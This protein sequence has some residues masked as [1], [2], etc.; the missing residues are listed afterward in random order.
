MID[1]EVLRQVQRL[2]RDAAAQFAALN[3]VIPRDAQLAGRDA[4]RA[5][6]R[7]DP[8]ALSPTARW[9]ARTG[10]A[11]FRILEDARR[12]QAA[13]QEILDQLA[14]GA[15]LISPS[16]PAEIAEDLS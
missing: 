9:V 2:Q 8:P 13:A 10:Q 1:P 11:V 6:G 4:R 16:A 3:R 15:G 14:P 5:T 7:P 12:S